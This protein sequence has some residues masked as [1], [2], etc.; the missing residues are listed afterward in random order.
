MHIDLFIEYLYIFQWNCIVIQ[1][2]INEWQTKDCRRIKVYSA[3]FCDTVLMFLKSIRVGYNWGSETKT[4]PFRFPTPPPLGHDR[5][6]IMVCKITIC[7]W[8]GFWLAKITICKWAGF[9][10]AKPPPPRF[11]HA[12]D[13]RTRPMRTRHMRIELGTNWSCI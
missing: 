12:N 3:N 2:K 1:W 5:S 6:D 7:K 11:F 9:W 10:L 13:M 4:P 8:A